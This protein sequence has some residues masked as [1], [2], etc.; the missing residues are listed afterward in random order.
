MFILLIQAK[1]ELR[2][3]LVFPVVAYTSEIL[4]LETKLI[5]F[6]KFFWAGLPPPLSQFHPSA[7]INSFTFPLPALKSFWKE[8]GDKSF[9]VS[10]HVAW[11]LKEYAP[12]PYKLHTVY[13]G[14][15]ALNHSYREGGGGHSTPTIGVGRM[16]AMV[17]KFHKLDL[18]NFVET[19]WPR[20]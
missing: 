13:R 16:R 17:P 9:K 7:A 6:C 8:K 11:H 2:H 5:P 1:R 18:R 19:S 20:G 15:W 10:F 14:G 4:K 3:L 12:P